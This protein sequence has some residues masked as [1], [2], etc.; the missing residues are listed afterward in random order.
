MGQL[1]FGTKRPKNISK[2]LTGHLKKS[3]STP[4]F[5][6]EIRVTE[7][8]KLKVGDTVKISDVFSVGDAV[9]AIG[10]SKGKGFAGAIKRW[11]FAA[12][13]RTHGQSDRRRAPGS[14]GQG[15]TPGRVHKGK[16]MPGRMG[17]TQATVRN[18]KVVS[19]DEAKNILEVSGPIPGPNKAKVI[20]KN[21]KN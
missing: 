10:V 8:P 14:I 7:E 20:V 12:G 15:T 18:L 11:G 2:P 1:G 13:P 4:R 21:E 16:K 6:N 3:K 9:T 5:I 17:T 19:I